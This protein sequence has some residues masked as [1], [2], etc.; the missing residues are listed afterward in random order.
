VGTAVRNFE[1]ASTAI[2]R[3]ST[4]IARVSE[5][6]GARTED[7]D[8]FITEAREL[9]SR[10]NAASV[11]VDGVLAKVDGLLASGDGESLFAEASETLRAYR[12]VAD[13]LNARI[14][15]IT[16]GLSRFSDQGLRNMEA[17]VRDARRSISRIERAV[18]EFEQN[19]QRIITGGDGTIRQYDGR[20]RR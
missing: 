10:L 1:E 9:A 18:S 4:D 8:R 6:I 2:N 20:V 7:I 5:T 12:Q 15:T 13:T 19:P 3:A 17:L 11:R 14:G 16:E